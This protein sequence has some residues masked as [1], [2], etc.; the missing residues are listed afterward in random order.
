MVVTGIASLELLLHY[1]QCN[2]NNC[3]CPKLNTVDN[4][5]YLGVYIDSNMKWRKHIYETTLK[6]L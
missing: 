2:R 3:N 6:L 4:S 5:N 1:Q